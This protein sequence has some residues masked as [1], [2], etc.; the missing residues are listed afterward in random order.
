[1]SKQSPTTTIR[2]PEE[3]RYWIGHRAVDNCRSVNS[4]ITML[5]KEVMTLKE[6]MKKKRLDDANK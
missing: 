6:E 5:L 2:L 3:L 4:E 1:M